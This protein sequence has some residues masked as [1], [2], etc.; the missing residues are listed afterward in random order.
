MTKKDSSDMDIKIEENEPETVAED[1]EIEGT[2][3][4]VDEVAEAQKAVEE[5]KLMAQ[6]IQAEFDN[7]R[8]RNV[9]AVRVSREE[10]KE[11][12][13]TALLSVLDN[14]ERGLN[15]LDAQSKPG[16]ELIYKQVLSILDKF[17]VKEIE[18]LNKPFDPQFH[19]AI[20]QCEDAEKANT[21]VEVFQ[22]GYIRKNKVLRP[23]LVKVAQ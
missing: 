8:K 2:I 22:K 17:E 4:I 16:V 20:A 18:A 6:R 1:T 5:Y 23:S 14:F 11:D 9:D 7:Y 13:L 15:A 3:E 10:G 19:H 12:V 21:V